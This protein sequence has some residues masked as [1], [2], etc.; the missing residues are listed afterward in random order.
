MWN[1]SNGIPNFIN[2]NVLNL[3]YLAHY[4]KFYLY[5][6]WFKSAHCYITNLKYTML[7][8]LEKVIIEHG[9][10]IITDIK[11]DTEDATLIKCI[12]ILNIPLFFFF[13][14]EKLESNYIFTHPFRQTGIMATEEWQRCIKEWRTCN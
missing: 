7:Y 6:K 11:I 8:W 12:L 14:N 3:Y 2:V 9:K 1:V 5:F 13:E 4:L 10:T